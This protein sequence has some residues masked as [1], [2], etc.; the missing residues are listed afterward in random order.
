MI[1]IGEIRKGGE[2]GKQG[3]RTKF[4]WAACLDCGKERWVTWRAKKKQ[5][6]SPR[7]CSCSH[8]GSLSVHRLVMAQSLGRCLTKKEVVHHLNG[9][10]ADNRIENL[11]LTTT[12]KHREIIAAFNKRIQELENKMYQLKH[13]LSY[14]KSLSCKRNFNG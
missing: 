6:I 7:C 9:I 4:I 12:Q 1:K 8:Q 3:E 13:S 14:W 2:I 11:F 10:R 5:P